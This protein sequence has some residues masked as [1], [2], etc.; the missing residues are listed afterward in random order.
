MRFRIM[1]TAYENRTKRADNLQGKGSMKKFFKVFVL[2]TML[3]VPVVADAASKLPAGIIALSD[4]SMTWADAKTW[5]QQRSGR[6][7][8]IGGGDSRPDV[9]PSGTPIDGFGTVD[10]PW[11]VGLPPG[12]Y[13]TGTE[14]G[15]NR[16]SPRFSWFVHGGGNV[17][18]RF[19]RS[20]DNV[21][22]APYRQILFLRVVC[23]P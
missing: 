22:V 10:A 5:C 2:A 8:F 1:P 3:A 18:S 9:P 23:V 16:S 12:H 14:Y 19:F 6:L 13:W 4:S 21:D 7:P 11:P 20:S 15:D 17:F